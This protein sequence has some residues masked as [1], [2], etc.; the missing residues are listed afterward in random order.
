MTTELLKN[1]RIKT[2][3][4]RAKEVRRITDKMIT[5]GKAGDLAARRQANA[6]LL[7]ENVVKNLFAEVAGKY[8]DRQGG[9]TRISK[10][11]ERRV[12]AAAMVILELV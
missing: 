8:A 3:E 1:G 10:L 5:L 6:Y 9:Y 7:D 4:A 11:G 12:D 2:T